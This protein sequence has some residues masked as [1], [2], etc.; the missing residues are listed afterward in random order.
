MAGDGRQHVARE[1][2]ALTWAAPQ[3]RE[4]LGML[5]ADWASGAIWRVTLVPVR[6]HHAF[7]WPWEDPK[8]L[9]VW[10]SMACLP[11]RVSTQL[12]C[13]K[14]AGLYWFSDSFLYHSGSALGTYNT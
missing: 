3:G 4:L 1:R 7:A 6:E 10:D 5:W 8:H 9:W 12:T 11:L 2:T 14:A 13:P